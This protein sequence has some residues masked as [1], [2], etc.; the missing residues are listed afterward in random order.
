MSW[1]YQ[2]VWREDEGERFYSVAEVYFDE[3]GRLTAWTEDPL[4]A[5]GGESPGD[6][7]WSVQ[8]MATDCWNWKPVAFEALQVGMIFERNRPRD[9]LWEEIGRVIA[10]R[11]GDA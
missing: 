7:I 8:A 1:R 2:A 10:A 4:I 6:L 9:E 11:A 3:D 5:P